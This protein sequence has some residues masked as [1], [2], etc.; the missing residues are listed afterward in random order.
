M[1]KLYFTLFVLFAVEIIAKGQAPSIALAS[2][3]SVSANPIPQGTYVD[4]TVTVKNNGSTTGPFDFECDFTTNGG[5]WISTAAKLCN[6]TIPVGGTKTLNFSA[7]GGGTDRNPILSSPASNYKINIITLYSSCFQCGKSGC[8]IGQVSSGSYSN[9][10]TISVVSPYCSGTTNLT[11]NSDSF[12]D[13]SGSSNYGC[14]QNCSWIIK[15]TGATSIT[16]SFSSFATESGFDFLI[17]YDGYNNS[18]SRIGYFSGSSIPSS[19]NSSGGTMFVQFTSDKAT[20][21]AGW[22]ANYTSKTSGTLTAPANFQILNYGP[23]TLRAAWDASAGATSYDLWQ[24]CGSSS[25]INTTNTYYDFTS[26]TPGQTYQY[27]VEAKNS[28]SKAA[29][30]CSSGTLPDYPPSLSSPTNG[31]SGIAT[32]NPAFSWSNS[33]NNSQFYLIQISDNSNFT[34]PQSSITTS[35]NYTHTNTTLNSN[36][37]YYWRVAS[38]IYNG[39]YYNGN[40]SNYFS[41]KTGSSTTT[42]KVSGNVKDN[43][44]APLSGVNIN[45][46]SNNISTNTNGDYSFTVTNPSNGTVTPS[47]GGYT[48]YPTSIYVSANGADQLNNN[49]IGTPSTNTVNVSGYI[50]DASSSGISNVSIND[51][52]SNIATTNTNGFYS[53]NPIKPYSKTITPIKSGYTFSPANK[54]FSNIS[55]NQTQINFTGTPSSIPTLILLAPKGGEIWYEGSTHNITWSSNGISAIRIDL[56]TDNGATWSAINRV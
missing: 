45:Y 3:I 47:L 49:F 54:T 10:L 22:T 56:S 27:L 50:R 41:F 42:N 40:Y 39:N 5:T 16:L 38:A 37:T 34:A 9:P 20:V 26:L 43:S 2:A 32:S 18:A 7:T 4:I 6:I 36:I 29:T 52:T 33:P 11:N 17:V 25:K 8:S 51:G 23:T 48:F 24:N 21:A 31:A 12:E 14:S 44:N 55:I 19:V 46:G 53:F 13:G 35:T 30:S 28:T 15:P 1:K